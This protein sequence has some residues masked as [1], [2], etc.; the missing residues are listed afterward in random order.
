MN[1]TVTDEAASPGYIR[2]KLTSLEISIMADERTSTGSGNTAIVAIVVLVLVA[3]LAFFLFFRPSGE[4][5]VE[6][7]PDVELEVNPPGEGG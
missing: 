3:I 7:G 4:A 2:G 6:T 1:K 5:P